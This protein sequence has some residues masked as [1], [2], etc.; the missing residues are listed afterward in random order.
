M[1]DQAS[2]ILAFLLA[3]GVPGTFAAAARITENPGQAFLVT[4]LYSVVAVGF[5]LVTGL[6][7][8]ASKR[9][10]DNTDKKL[11][12]RAEGKKFR[13]EYLKYIYFKHRTFDVKG[14]GVQGPFALELQNV[15]VDLSISPE[16]NPTKNP[17]ESPELKK[18]GH[19]IWKFLA[20]ERVNH[21]VIIGPPGSGKTTLLKH[22]ALCLA[23]YAKASASE[24]ISGRVPVLLFLRDHAKIIANDPKKTRLVE[25]IRDS[26]ELMEAK[27]PE[28]WFEELLREGKC[29]VMLDGLDEVG[30]TDDRRK[31]AQWV[32]AQIESLGGNVFIITSRPHGYTSNPLVGVNLLEVRSFNRSQVKQFV[33]HWYLANQIMAHHKDDPGVHLE[34]QKGAADLLRRINNS[35][36]ISELAV[37]PLLLTMI[38]NVHRFRSSLPGRRVELYAEVCDVFLGKRQISNNLE[39]DLTPAQKISILQPLAYKFMRDATR[40]FKTADALEVIDGPLKSVSD[41][42]SGLEFLKSIENGSGILL[43]RENG[44]YAFAH[45]TFQEYLTA[46]HIEKQQ[47]AAILLDQLDSDWWHETIRL[48]CARNDASTIIEACLE[49]NASNVGRFVLAVQCSDEALKVEP[50]IRN[51]VKDFVS[52]SADSTDPNVW[53]LVVRAK[54]KMRLGEIKTP[55]DDDTFVDSSP[56]TCAEYQLFIEEFQDDEYTPDHWVKRRFAFNTANRPIEGL[57]SLQA[58]GFVRWLTERE[59][60]S[61]WRYRLPNEGEIRAD[62]P[63][64]QNGLEGLSLSVEPRSEQLIGWCIDNCTIHPDL[65]HHEISIHGYDVIGTQELALAQDLVQTLA[66]DHARR[67]VHDLSR[68]RSD[69]LAH[70]K[71]VNIARA[72][73]RALAKAEE[74]LPLIANKNQSNTI[75]DRALVIGRALATALTGD[76]SR[77]LAGDRARDR[78]RG[79][80]LTRANDLAQGLTRDHSLA[81]EIIQVLEVWLQSHPN[82]QLVTVLC[83]VAKIIDGYFEIAELLTCKF[84]VRAIAKMGE[85]PKFRIALLN[86]ANDLIENQP[87]RGRRGPNGDFEKGNEQLNSALR[88]YAMMVMLEKRRQGEK[89]WEAFEEIRIVKVRLT[90]NDII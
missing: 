16:N 89:G 1:G 17:I 29:V 24:V 43:Q 35:P 69:A 54:L 45:K 37:N 51:K 61:K 79:T 64:W 80:I 22:V 31:I 42:I 46:V 34:A 26:V 86:R 6:W 75:G 87:K 36:E 57:T 27:A 90:E 62:Y 4:V 60:G 10:L 82:D 56:I 84:P 12:L 58:D 52:Q 23:G 85:L 68:A 25:L 30:D 59:G 44:E 11:V 19:S 13:Q 40:E 28:R 78:D 70:D 55:I 39:L 50:H 8:R 21:L 66:R 2:I 88:A 63:F 47:L 5:S 53:G 18:G 48:Y 72:L 73:D 49:N 15:F 74:L 81:P 9:I 67:L 77:A 65:R 14:L 83:S 76:L 7:E 20:D 32:N 33:E 71:A 38:A 3:I 41:K